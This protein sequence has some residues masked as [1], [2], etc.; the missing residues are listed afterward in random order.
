MP[1][2]EASAAAQNGPDDC[3]ALTLLVINS[4]EWMRTG[5]QP[6]L[7][8]ARLRRQYLS[9]GESFSISS[10][11]I[12]QV[13]GTSPDQREFLTHRV[14]KQGQSGASRV[15]VSPLATGAKLPNTDTRLVRWQLSDTGLHTY[16]GTRGSFDLSVGLLNAA[17]SR[18]DPVPFTGTIK[19]EGA[20]ANADRQDLSRLLVILLLCIMVV[21][22]IVAAALPRWRRS[23]GPEPSDRQG[24]SAATNIDGG[25]V[26]Q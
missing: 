5:E 13:D 6:E 12:D 9:T 14:L 22:A 25:E 4:I 3:L 21:E 26:S 16:R 24:D 19:I 18:L 2:A 23:S 20:A 10:T 7:R 15:F 8:A 1:L 11:A 17:E